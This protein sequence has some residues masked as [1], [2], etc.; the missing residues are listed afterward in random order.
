MKTLEIIGL[1][2]A[3][4]GKKK[5]SHSCD[6][7][8]LQPRLAIVKI[9]EQIAVHTHSTRRWR[10]FVYNYVMFTSCTSLNE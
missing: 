4:K 1:M 7:Y 9:F 3:L 10:S 8:V 2:C 5:N 6:F